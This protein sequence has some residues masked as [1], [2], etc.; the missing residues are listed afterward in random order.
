MS[1]VYYN[2]HC[3]LTENGTRPQTPV[4]RIFCNNVHALVFSDFAL[5]SISKLSEPA[6]NEAKAFRYFLRVTISR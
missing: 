5:F 3:K 4:C 1:D 2:M 6:L